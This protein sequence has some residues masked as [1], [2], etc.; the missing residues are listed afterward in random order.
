M[1]PNIHLVLKP[2][3]L[4]DLSPYDI[5]KVKAV[6]DTGIVIAHGA[7]CFFIKGILPGIKPGDTLF[8]YKDML[9]PKEQPLYI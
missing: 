8:L 9:I 5:F 4:A 2:E 1:L 6:K 3:E 7:L